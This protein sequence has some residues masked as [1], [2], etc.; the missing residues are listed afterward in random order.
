MEF[1]AACGFPIDDLIDRLLAGSI[2]WTGPHD[3]C[4]RY[5]PI[6]IFATDPMELNA[7][8]PSYQPDSDRSFYLFDG[9]FSFGEDYFHPLL[10]GTSKG[11]PR[12]VDDMLDNDST[13]ASINAGVFVAGRVDRR[14]LM[15]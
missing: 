2:G 12:R 15:L 13:A 14:G 3:H 5:G 11:L 7:P 6:A 1:V 10:V 8:R 4:V 9:Q